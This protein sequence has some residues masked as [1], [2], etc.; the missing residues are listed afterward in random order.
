M[1]CFKK[2]LFYHIQTI[3]I[4]IPNL[5]EYQDDI[6]EIINHY[7]YQFVD[8]ENLPYR[9]FSMQAL[10]FLRQ[11]EWPGNVREL[12]NFVQRVLVLSQAEE[13]SLSVVEKLLHLHTKDKEPSDV[14]NIDLP[15]RDA[16]EKF[17]KSYF[18]NQL[19]YCEGNIAKLAERSGLERTNLYRKLKSLGIQYK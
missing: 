10:N 15:I 12:K 9:H 19:K 8:Y 6:P 4:K 16:R 7:V 1:L 13:I 18:M 14:V 11:Y 2:E 5:K 3:S 17:E